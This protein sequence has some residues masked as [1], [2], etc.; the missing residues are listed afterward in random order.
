MQLVLQYSPYQYCYFS[1][2]DPVLKTVLDQLIIKVM[3]S[4]PSK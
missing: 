1:A 2:M 3:P 4:N